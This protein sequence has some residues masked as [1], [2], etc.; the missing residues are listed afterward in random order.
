[1]FSIEN[2]CKN[3]S[4]IIARELELSQDKKEV[5][6]YGIFGVIQTTIAIITVIIVG[7]I[8]NVVT[9]ALLVSIVISILRKSSGGVHASTPWKCALMGAIISVVIGKIC[10]INNFGI[11]GVVFLGVIVFV[12]AFYIVNKLAPVDS[13]SKPI[14]KEETRKR[15]KR[16]SL[17]VL[18]IY[19]II[20]ICNIKLYYFNG[21]RKLI[22]YILCIYMGMAWQVFSLTKIGHVIIRKIDGVFQ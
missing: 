20:I 18:I 13:L 6:N 10:K 9:E 12:W 15:L 4:E 1:M 2:I 3:I 7:L 8:F 19:M 5:I 14:R 16:T 17:N 21:N 22:I 11:I